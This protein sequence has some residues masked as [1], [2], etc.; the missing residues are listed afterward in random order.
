MG[1]VLKRKTKFITYISLIG[2]VI[3]LSMN[4]FMIP[5]YGMMG[6]AISTVVTFSVLTILF[7]FSNK[8]LYSIDYEWRRMIKIILAAI[9]VFSLGYFIKIDHGFISIT[10]KIF[11]IL[12]GE[13]LIYAN[14]RILHFTYH[15]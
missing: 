1:V 4:L 10:Y 11:I 3:N 14:L 5:H 12:A 6:A 9:L 8:R 7:Y 15:P 2:G 13:S